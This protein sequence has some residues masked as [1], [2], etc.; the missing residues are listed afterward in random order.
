MHARSFIAQL[1]YYHLDL[2]KNLTPSP[3][4]IAI[5]WE[6]PVFPSIAIALRKSGIGMFVS[7]DSSGGS[8]IS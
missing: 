3:S 5:I 4:G 2:A 1:Q 8:V 6:R 7:G